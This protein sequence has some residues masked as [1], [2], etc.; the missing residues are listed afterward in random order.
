M[1]EIFNKEG[2][3]Y[4]CKE[5]KVKIRE[6]YEIVHRVERPTELWLLLREALKGKKVKVVVY[7]VEG[8]K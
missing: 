4:T 3:F 1:R 2:V 7:E 5:R 8:E 6:G